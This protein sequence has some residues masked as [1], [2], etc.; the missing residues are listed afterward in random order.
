MD[1][2]RCFLSVTRKGLRGAGIGLCVGG[3][4]GGL[5]ST[6]LEG[7]V[8]LLDETERFTAIGPWVYFFV[9]VV[10]FAAP[11]SI[12]AGAAGALSQCPLVR[13]T[14]GIAGGSLPT[15]IL[16]CEFWNCR[17]VP[18][19]WPDWPYNFLVIGGGPLVAAITAGAIAAGRG[20]R[21]PMKLSAT[22]P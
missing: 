9:G 19:D 1:D 15:L 10:M 2:R 22:Q 3:A 12:I 6:V 20:S 18:R 8:V 11:G 7:G 21:P 4:V 16:S 17:N 13:I 14:S 5:M